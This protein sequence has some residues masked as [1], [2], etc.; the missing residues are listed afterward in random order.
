MH[1]L[2]VGVEHLMT[3]LQLATESGSEIRFDRESASIVKVSSTSKITAYWPVKQ[4]MLES[5]EVD[6]SMSSEE[7]SEGEVEW[8][9]KLT[10]VMRSHDAVP[11]RA[12]TLPWPVIKAMRR[13]FGREANAY[14]NPHILRSYG[15][16]WGFRYAGI[17]HCVEPDGY[18]HT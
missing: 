5:T 18:I 10:E 14:L 2:L 1:I 15:S 16:Y 13:K 4:V 17:F 3:G 7:Y 12:D 9:V 8:A 6:A 11:F